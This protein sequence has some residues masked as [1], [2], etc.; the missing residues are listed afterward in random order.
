MRK[1]GENY[2]GNN[3]WITSSSPYYNLETNKLKIDTLY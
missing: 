2:T 3:V 1:P